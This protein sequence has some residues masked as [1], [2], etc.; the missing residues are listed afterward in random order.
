MLQMVLCFVIIRPYA[1]VVR[2]VNT[3]R[4]PEQHDNARAKTGFSR[5]VFI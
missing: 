3:G 4:Y 1:R 5:Y 2:S